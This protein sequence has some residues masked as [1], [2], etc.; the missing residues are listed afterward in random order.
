MP[1]I[2]ENV[3]FYKRSKSSFTVLA[4]TILTFA[5]TWGTAS[6]LSSVVGYGLATGAFAGISPLSAG[7]NGAGVYAGVVGL[8][9]AVLIDAQAGW[10]GSTGN[11]VL[12]PNIGPMDKH[13]KTTYARRTKQANQQLSSHRFTRR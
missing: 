9:G 4:F 12:K 11:G 2:E 3:Y 13:Q 5:V 6:A 7:L 1:E 8:N 10:T